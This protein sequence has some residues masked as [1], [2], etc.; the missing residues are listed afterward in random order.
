VRRRLCAWWLAGC[1]LLA[2]GCYDAR[3]MNH[4]ALVVAV[5]IDKVPETGRYLVTAQIARPGSGKGS[6]GGGGDASGGAPVYIASGDGDTLFAAIRNLAEFVSRRI[7]WAHNNVVVV[8]ESVAREDLTPVMDFFTRNQEL[9]MR[10]WIVVA[11]GTEARQIVALRTGIEQVP[12]DSIS[13]LFRYAQLPGESVRS[14]VNEVAAA[15]FGPDVHPVIAAMSIQDRAYQLSDQVEKPMLPQAELAGTAIINRNRVVGYVQRGTGRGLLWLRRQLENPA[16]EVP[17]PPGYDGQISVEV[18]SPK[19]QIRSFLTRNAPSFQ[20]QVQSVAWLT[21]QDCA[22][23][24]LTTSQ[25]K[26]HVEQA[27]DRKIKQEIEATLQVLQG[28]LKTDAI[29]FGRLVHIQHPQWWRANRERWE[30]LFP[31][32]KVTVT[33]QT[34]IPKMGLYVRPMR[35]HSP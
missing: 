31:T 35:L 34:R 5:G 33:V 30:E 23:N 6:R 18:R 15:Y 25:L 1:L 8:G 14:D 20:V 12:A 29:R 22:T 32:S 4:L 16:L 2:A 17:C 27:L 28:D 10:T 7:M 19:V 21:E 11:K 9:R 13:A 26:T 24:T 3:E